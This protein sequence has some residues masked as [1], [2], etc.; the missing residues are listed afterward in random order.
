MYSLFIGL[1]LGGV[2]VVWGLARPADGRVFGGFVPAFALMLLLAYFDSGESASGSGFGLMFLAGVAGA[3]AMI[4]PGISGG[5]IL[6]LMGAYL[7]V[8][9]AISKVKDALKAGSPM[10]ASAEIMGVILPVGLGVVLGVL[11]VSNLIERL[12]KTHEKL[13]LG[14]LLGFLF[15][16]VL[17]LKPFHEFYRPDVDQVVRG[18]RMTA[19]RLAE[20]PQHKWPTRPF[21]PDTTQMVGSVG[22]AVLGFLLTALLAKYSNREPSERAT[23]DSED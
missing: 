1:T 6:I 13:T 18:V 5:Y 21:E 16:S 15:G 4:L 7:P 3:S 17:G 20:L 2:P 19:E 22:I 23:D 14:A 11:V 8:L 12:L 10:A 9:D